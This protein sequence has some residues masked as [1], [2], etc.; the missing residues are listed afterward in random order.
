MIDISPFCSKLQRV[1]PERVV[2]HLFTAPGFARDLARALSRFG[3]RRKNNSCVVVRKPASLAKLA[4]ELGLEGPLCDLLDAYAVPWSGGRRKLF[5]TPAI[6]RARLLAAAAVREYAGGAYCT[7][8]RSVSDDIGS[9][10]RS[11]PPPPTAPTPPPPPQ[12]TVA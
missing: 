2:L 7:G 11:P 1:A 6:R 9:P 12:P 8:P 10:N 5:V 3:A 4:R